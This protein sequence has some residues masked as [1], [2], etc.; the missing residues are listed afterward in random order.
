MRRHRPRVS[1]F[2]AGIIAAVVIAAAVYLAFGGSTPFAGSPF[3]L[4]AVFTTETELHIPS[5]VRI[6]GVDVG[7]VVSVKPLGGNTRAAVVTMDINRNGLPIH[8][9]ATAGILS[10]IF[11]EGNFYVDLHPGT[12]NAPLLSSGDTLPAPQTSGPVQLDRVLA[13]LTSGARQNLQTLVQGLGALAQ[14]PAH[15]WRRTPPRI[16]TRASRASPARRR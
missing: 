1:N 10:R 5:P 14:R 2:A 3:V 12:P 6:A 15:R 8:K 11:L 16:R 9:D 4:K 13:A 7:Q